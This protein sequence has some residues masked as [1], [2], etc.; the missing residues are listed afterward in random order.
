METR[1]QHDKIVH[2]LKDPKIIIKEVLKHFSPKT[3]IDLWCWL[4]TFVKV[5]QDNWVDAY[6]VNW[7]RIEKDKLFI[8]EKNL[9]IKNLEEFYD[10]W[11]KYDLAISLEVAEHIDEKYSDNFVKTLISCSDYI[12]FSAATSW[13]WWQNH[14]NEQRPEYREKKFN[15]YWYKF[16]D[17][18]RHIFWDDKNIFW[19]YK[20][21]MFLVAKEWKE[22]PKT[23][24]EKWPKYVIHPE[25]FEGIDIRKWTTKQL[26]KESIY[27]IY[28]NTF[29]KFIKIC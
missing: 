5:L 24:V 1:Y 29:G 22:I 21:N 3:A 9:I 27:R 26:V 2:N 6:W 4:G 28:M 23:L 25:L 10:F 15:K 8:D 20:Q 19:R 14:V 13:Q 16:Y 17:V 11:K 7:D 18:F 12:I